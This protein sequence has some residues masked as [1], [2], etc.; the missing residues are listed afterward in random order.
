MFTTTFTTGFP[1]QLFPVLGHYFL[2]FILLLSSHLHCSLLHSLFPADLPTKIYYTFFIT[3]MLHA[4]TV[5]SSFIW[6]SYCILK[7]TDYGD[8]YAVFSVILLHPSWGQIL[9]WAPCSQTCTVCER[10]SFTLRKQQVQSLSL[11]VAEMKTWDTEQH[12][13]KHSPNVICT[14]FFHECNFDLLPSFP[15][16]FATFY[17]HIILSYRLVIRH[18]RVLSFL[19]IYF[20]TNFLT[21]VCSFLY[22]QLLY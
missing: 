2:W 5:L 14:E 22:E 18:E 1:P 17:L 20:W 13:S 8:H 19:C 12:G 15:N 11:G 6:L 9:P 7:S 3:Y 4:M 10:P 16:N 21:I